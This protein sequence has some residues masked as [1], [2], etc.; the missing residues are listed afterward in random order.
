MKKTN[1]GYKPDL[2]SIFGWSAA[3]LFVQA[4]SKAGK[5][6]TRGSVMAQLKKISKFD[7]SGLIAP[8]NP[9]KKLSPNCYMNAKIDNGKYVRTSPKKGW[10]CDMPAYGLHGYEPKVKL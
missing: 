7:A 9:A 8:A 10:I 6:P 2:F 4:L 3:Q 5:N 1:P